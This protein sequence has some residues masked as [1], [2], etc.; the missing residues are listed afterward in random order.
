MKPID[1]QIKEL[2]DKENRLK[3]SLDE[4]SGSRQ[5][6]S[7][8]FMRITIGATLVALGIFILFRRSSTIKE[9]KEKQEVKS[10]N[11]NR[12]LEFGL[13]YLQQI[14]DKYFKTKREKRTE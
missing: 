14:L 2:E 1:E 9:S 7:R 6:R 5:S 10:N 4:I 13:P 12:I 11:F 3:K 8:G